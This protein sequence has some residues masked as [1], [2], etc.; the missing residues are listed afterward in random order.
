MIAICEGVGESGFWLLCEAD[1]SP[2]WDNTVL[3][4]LLQL[5]FAGLDSKL[6]ASMEFI[7]PF[8]TASYHQTPGLSWTSCGDAKKEPLVKTKAK[9]IHPRSRN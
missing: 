2:L 9:Y 8:P 1:V 3:L 5:D 7:E 6:T 4:A